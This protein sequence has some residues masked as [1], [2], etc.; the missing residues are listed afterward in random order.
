M[1]KVD[2]G[3][4]QLT[5]GTLI[6]L[7]LSGL[8]CQDTATVLA[9]PDDAILEDEV[10]QRQ[11]AEATLSVLELTDVTAGSDGAVPVQCEAP[12]VLGVA[13]GFSAARYDGGCCSTQAKAGEGECRP[14]HGGGMWSNGMRRNQ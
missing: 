4:T 5:L 3:R 8:R 1:D 12:A 14:N 10:A 6:T 13:S 7:P 11:A 9:V 2:E